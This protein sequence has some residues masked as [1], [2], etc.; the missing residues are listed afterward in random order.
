LG[1]LDADSGDNGWVSY[2]LLPS[3]EFADQ[4][5]M[6][7]ETGKFSIAPWAVVFVELC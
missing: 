7:D 6:D 5:N 1:A 3:S 4:F 2:S